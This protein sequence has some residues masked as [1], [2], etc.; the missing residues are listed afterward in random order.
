M[1]DYKISQLPVTTTAGSGDF[2]V[3]NT[4]NTN[5]NRIDVDNLL[6]TGANARRPFLINF[7]DDPGFSFATKGWGHYLASPDTEEDDTGKQNFVKTMKLYDI[8]K[9]VEPVELTMPPGC[10]RAV[11]V[12]T[13]EAS[14]RTAPSIDIYNDT[15]GY[16]NVYYNLNVTTNKSLAQW[17]PGAN[18]AFVVACK[19]YG[20]RMA[21][22]QYVNATDYKKDAMLP[23]QSQT[24]SRVT[25]LQ[26]DESTAENPTKLTFSPFA[27]ISRM[28]NST[29]LVS[30]G[31][32]S[33]FPYKEDELD[34]YTLQML[35]AYA[36]N[37]SFY[38][39]NFV[40]D[41]LT[42]SDEWLAGEASAQFKNQIRFIATSVDET[43]RW[44][45]QITGNGSDIPENTTAKNVLEQALRDLFALKYSTETDPEY[46]ED[47]MNT[48]VQAVL[49]YVGFNF[50]FENSN[51]R[52][53]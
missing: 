40:D 17:S 12:L 53:F 45:V 4:A 35:D 21:W 14:T 51:N 23:Q 7:K 18:N 33:V 29:V 50:A 44:D 39:D 13:Y 46:Y 38:Q 9:D 16:A 36:S 37:D 15:V 27:Y 52:S 42:V 25:R 5:T 8:F 2:V 24:A 28:K 30:T 26:Y 41:E 49:P 47:S 34:P 3:I 10:D 32:I 20:P 1:P 11:V 19:M 48:I 6:S 43:L 31:R 22:N